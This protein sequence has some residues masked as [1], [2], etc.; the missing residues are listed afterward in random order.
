MVFSS[1]EQC[2]EIN[3][4]EEEDN[5]S[6]GKSLSNPKSKKVLWIFYV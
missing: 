1:K 2:V 3:L 5:K 4:P 6:K